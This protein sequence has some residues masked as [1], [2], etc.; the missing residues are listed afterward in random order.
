MHGTEFR[1]CVAM[2]ALVAGM[3]FYAALV[4]AAGASA[5][6]SAAASPVRGFVTGTYGKIDNP[7]IRNE[8]Q[9]YDNEHLVDIIPYGD[10]TALDA[11][12]FTLNN[13]DLWINDEY[14]HFDVKV[15][16]KFTGTESIGSK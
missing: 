6:T 12:C 14:G 8:L 16:M 5:G 2:G 7:A 11:P 9:F 10:L 4:A 3:G 13:N 15:D 1:D